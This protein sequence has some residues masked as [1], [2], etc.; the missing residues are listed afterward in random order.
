[1]YTRQKHSSPSYSYHRVEYISWSST[2]VSGTLQW[3]WTGGGALDTMRTQTHHTVDMY[4]DSLQSRHVASFPGLHAQLLSLAVQK[5]G[6]RPGRISHVLQ[7]T[8]AGHGGLGT[9]EASRHVVS[10]PDPNQPQCGLLPVSCAGREGQVK[11]LHKIS[12]LRN[13]R[14]LNLIGWLASNDVWNVDAV[15]CAIK[16]ML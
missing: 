13:F 14:G 1:M 12:S 7:V 5:A 15:L 16:F 6:G 11:L 4:S 9:I 10:A 3:S 8:K 2:H